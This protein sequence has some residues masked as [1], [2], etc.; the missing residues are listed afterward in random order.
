M[1][2]TAISGSTQALD[3][4]VIREDDYA[5]TIET[6]YTRRYTGS[7]TV[8]CIDGVPKRV[9]FPGI[10]VLLVEGSLDKREKLVDP[11]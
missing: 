9:E 8:H 2:I 4:L 3:R 5:S 1:T 11:T 6:I 10:Q 7:F